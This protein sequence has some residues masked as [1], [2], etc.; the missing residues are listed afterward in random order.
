MP[1]ALPMWAQL[2]GAYRLLS[3]PEVTYERVIAPHWDLVGRRC[4]EPG[5]YL[6]IEDTTD[7]D[8]TGRQAGEQMGWT[9]DC[10]GR[11]LYL[12]SCLAAQ[13][14]AWQDDGEPVVDVVGLLGQR[15]WMRLHD[16]RNG[17]E[18]R[19]DRMKRPRESERWAAVFEHAGGPP[20]GAEWVYVADRESDIYEALLDCRAGGVGFVV[21]ANQ[22]RALW[23]EKGHQ[24]HL[25]EAAAAG[26]VLGRLE[27][28]LRARKGVAART[29]CLELRSATVTLRPPHR[30]GW[31]LDPLTV[32][33]VEAREVGPGT[34]KEPLCW[35]LLTSLP[36][37]CLEDA[38]RAV[39]IYEQR[40][41][42]EEY[43]KALKTGARMEQTQ[44]ETPQRITA[45]LGVNAVVAV[46]LLQMKLLARSRPEEQVEE[47]AIGGEILLI[48][49]AV[50]G[51]PTR[52]WT[53]KELLVRIARL[54]GFLA[55]KGDGLPGWQTIWRGWRRLMSMA[56]GFN[57]A[58]GTEKCG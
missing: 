18:R 35:V 15:W 21:R 53:N 10:G 38:H 5:L 14:R 1:G 48:L 13:V 31:K 51:P 52:G 42:V 56:E 19:K 57:L 8:F 20:P 47:G 32:N 29:V 17:Q 12:H 45:L 40:W 27:K 43:H 36:C 24:G 39:C 46:R 49:A 11:G 34:A 7:L 44:L 16:P 22:D 2:K 37:G 3:C 4:G 55:R 30:P 50:F 28:K 26:E 9:G 25:F 33:L 41:L 23:G 54:G 6:T 58:L